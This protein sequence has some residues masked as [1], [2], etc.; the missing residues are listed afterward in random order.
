MILVDTSLYIEAAEKED[1]R[2]LLEAIA[3][4]DFVLSCDPVEKE[5]DRASDF[6]RS[7]GK[8]EDSE[9]LKLIYSELKQGLISLTDRIINLTE[10]YSKAADHLSKDQHKQMNND[11][12]IVASASVASVKSILSLNRKTMASSQMIE[13]YNKINKIN[14]YKTPTFI[15]TIEGLSK[16]LQP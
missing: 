1:I 3:K 10:A 7:I 11:L 9:K 13:V 16:L 6:L 12:R 8:R 4:T 2:K 5:V 14:G 15:T